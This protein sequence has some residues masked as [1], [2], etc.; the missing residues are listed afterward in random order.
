MAKKNTPYQFHRLMVALDASELDTQ[1][2]CTAAQLANRLPIEKIYFYHIS[3]TLEL[4][5]EVQDKLPDFAPADEAAEQNITEKL[6]EYFPDPRTVDIEVEV[7]E[8]DPADKLLRLVKSKHIDLLLVGRKS[9]LKGSGTTANKLVKAAP[10]S[11]MFVPESA[12]EVFKNILV[13][14]DFSDHATFA[15]NQAVNLAKGGEGEIICH[16][17]VPVPSGYHTS[18]KTREEFGEIMQGHAKKEYEHFIKDFDAQGVTLRPFFETNDDNNPADEIYE[19]AVS[20]GVDLIVLGSK[21]RKGISNV[22]LG[23]VAKRVLDFSKDIPVLVVKHKGEGLNFLQAL[24]R[25]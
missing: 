5:K 17:V 19:R 10:C 15:L 24:L 12:P 25:L 20:E 21:G 6:K 18:G 8:G 3:K 13:P 7:Q 23:S 22:L 1:L 16:N 14:V 9:S 4:P 11:V 2:M